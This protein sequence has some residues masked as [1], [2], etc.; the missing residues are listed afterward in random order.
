V[1]AW[2]EAVTNLTAP[3]DD[4]AFAAMQAHFDDADIV[5]LTFLASAWNLSNRFAEALHLVVE[6]PGQRIEFGED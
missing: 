4:A 1:I 2:A 3:A 5:E 6:P